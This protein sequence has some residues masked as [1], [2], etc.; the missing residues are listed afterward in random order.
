[1]LD[2][3]RPDEY[4]ASIFYIDLDQ[5]KQKGIKGLIIDIDNTLVEWGEKTADRRLLDWFQLLEEKGFRACI[6]SNNTKDRVVTFTER[7]RVPAVYRAGKP[8]KRAFGR[9]MKMMGTCSSNTAVIGDQILTDIFG[10]NRM[11]LYTILVVPVGSREFITTK[12]M[13]RIE[14]R[15]LKALLCRGEI[16]EPEGWKNN[17]Y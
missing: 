15:I 4:L 14:R 8:R 10:G 1:M 11:G 13:R 7:I 5:M 6:L 17:E 16:N 9:A 2:L 12:I 3:F